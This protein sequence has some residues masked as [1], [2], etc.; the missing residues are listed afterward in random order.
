MT[1]PTC[2]DECPY[3]YQKEADDEGEERY[4]CQCIQEDPC[5]SKVSLIKIK[6]YHKHK[7]CII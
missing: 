6:Y 4:T 5:D 2:P 1:K 3:G 7:E